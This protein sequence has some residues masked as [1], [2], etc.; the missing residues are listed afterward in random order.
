MEVWRSKT[1]KAFGTIMRD[2][3]KDQDS[4]SQ[5][6]SLTSFLDLIYESD[7]IPIQQRFYHIWFN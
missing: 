1:G 3:P 5:L 2:L 6:K 7:K 4:I